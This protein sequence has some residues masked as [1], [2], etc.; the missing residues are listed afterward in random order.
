MTTRSFIVTKLLLLFIG[1]ISYN[2]MADPAP[3]GLELN[4][5]S[6]AELK[7]KYAA[8]SLGFNKNNGLEAFDIDPKR[9]PFE[10]LLSAKAAFSTDGLL[11]LVQM[12]LPA[13]KFSLLAGELAKKYALVYKNVPVDGNKEA[14]FEQDNTYILLYVLKNSTE[15]DFLY[16]NKQLLDETLGVST[17]PKIPAKPTEISLL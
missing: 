9:I 14:K 13:D 8:T 16:I 5:T 2:V 11:K 6:I 3:F 10:G 7:Q 15:M 4:K 12:S 17:A 1:I